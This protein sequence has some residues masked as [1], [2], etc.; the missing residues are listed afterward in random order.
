MS[1]LRAAG[2]IVVGKTNTP[3]F[4][5]TAFTHNRLF[6]TSRNPWNLERTP[7]GSSGGSSA[8]VAARMVPL[9]TGSVDHVLAVECVFHFPSRKAFFR[10]AARVL[11]PGGHAVLTF[12]FRIDLAETLTRAVREPD[13]SV[14][15]LLPAEYH[16]DPLQPDGVLC[17]YHFGWDILDSM[18]GA[19]F[20]GASCHLYWSWELGYLGGLGILVHGVR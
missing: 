6:G 13:G 11:R 17:Y 16:G 3:E 18:R 19:G 20:T 9:A 5:C 14:R 15:H 12:P 10:E 1:R 7:G 2:A 8:A 4:G